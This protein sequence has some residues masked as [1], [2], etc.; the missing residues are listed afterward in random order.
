MSVSVKVSGFRELDRALALL[1]K[2]AAKATLIRTLKKAA[3]PM[4]DHASALA[5][6]DT[7]ELRSSIIVSSKLANNIGKREFHEVMKAGGTRKEA[8]KAMHLARST[9]QGQSFAVVYM[10]PSQ[11][12]SKR[13]GIKRMAQEFGTIRHAPNPYMRPAWEAKKMSSLE[14]IRR[15]LAQEIMNTAR[16]IGVSKR[17]SYT[18]EIKASASTAAM[19]ASEV[20]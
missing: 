17:A 13:D 2:A 4:A 15:E 1:P 20:D 10:G 11:A 14:I 16:R 18:A 6:V 7:G 12:K 5:P 8:G 9:A 3:Q 19:L